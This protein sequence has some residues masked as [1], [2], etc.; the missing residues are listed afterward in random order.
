MTVWNFATGLWLFIPVQRYLKTVS[1]ILYLYGNLLHNS[2]VLI[3]D[4]NTAIVERA[5]LAVIDHVRNETECRKNLS[6]CME[7]HLDMSYDV[8]SRLFSATCSIP[9]IMN[10]SNMYGDISLRIVAN[11]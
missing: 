4:P 1:R 9:A 3:Q 7:E 6:A 5:K 11:E 10:P 8:I 2:A